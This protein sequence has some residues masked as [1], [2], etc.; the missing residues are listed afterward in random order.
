MRWVFCHAV[1]RRVASPPIASPC[2]QS[3]AFVELSQ[4]IN[5]HVF[6]RCEVTATAP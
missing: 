5:K 3:K 6:M 1:M 4:K 2:K